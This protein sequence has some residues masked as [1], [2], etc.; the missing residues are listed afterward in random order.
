M[1]MTF[2]EGVKQ[3]TEKCDKNHKKRE[4]FMTHKST[5]WITGKEMMKIPVRKFQDK[6]H[7]ITIDKNTESTN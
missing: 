2:I 5:V 7:E 4:P 1:Y 3:Y 6:D